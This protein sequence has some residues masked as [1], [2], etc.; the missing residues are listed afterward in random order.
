MNDTELD[1]SSFASSFA[2]LAIL[3]FFSLVLL[4]TSTIINCFFFLAQFLYFICF[5]CLQECLN[6][7][8]CYMVFEGHTQSLS[9]KITN[10]PDQLDL[11]FKEFVSSLMFVCRH[12]KRISNETFYLKQLFTIP[13]TYIHYIYRQIY[14]YQ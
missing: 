14:R 3:L 5:Q 4:L 9:P 8:N 11:L 13:D 1:A 6:G 10:S 2:I 7:S 12:A